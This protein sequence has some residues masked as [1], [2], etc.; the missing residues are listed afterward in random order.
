M[1]YLS[2]EKLRF[3]WFALHTNSCVF[4]SWRLML[5]DGISK[6]NK[7]EENPAGKHRRS[8]PVWSVAGGS[9]WHPQGCALQCSQILLPV[10][11]QHTWREPTCQDRRVEGR[12]SECKLHSILCWTTVSKCSSHE[13]CHK[14]S[15]CFTTQRLST[16]SAISP[17]NTSTIFLY[18]FNL[19]LNR[20]IRIVI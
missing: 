13:A 4:S 9:C 14:L 3:L 6:M 1:Q 10:H 20:L 2:N 7:T 15:F 18:T 12:K 17:P 8:L 16:S 19:L 11:L 5:S